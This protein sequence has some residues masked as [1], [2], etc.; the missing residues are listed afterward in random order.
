[1]EAAY[2]P[3]GDTRNALRLQLADYFEAQPITARTCDELP[4]L[5]K[6]I[7]VNARLR[8]C[9]LDIDRFLLI[10]ERD[11]EELRCYWVE[12]LHGE[13]DMGKS[14]LNSF[15]TWAFKSGSQ[16]IEIPYVA[17][18]LSLFLNEAAL[19]TEAEP[20]MRRA[21]EI[22]ERINGKEHPAVAVR[23][24][25]LALLLK[26]TNRFADAEPLMR[27]ALEIDEHSLGKD[28]P[29]VA[30]ELNNLSALLQATNRRNDAE[31]LLRRAL[32]I[33]E[34]SFGK[35]HPIV[36]LRLSNLA[37]LLCSTNRLTKA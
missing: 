2:A 12:Q 3:D 25:N 34:K 26:E 11:E 10:Y 28:H 32:E 31:P 24:N 17:N 1:M 16:E 4:W 8:A 30:R 14:Y 5:L 18:Q 19:Y 15:E 9:L 29:N 36:A 23:L 35:D 22:N 33:S 7:G 6:E 13:Q 37:Q 21:L 27:R 20:L